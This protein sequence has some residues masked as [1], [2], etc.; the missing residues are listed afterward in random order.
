MNI[1][2]YRSGD[3]EGVARLFNDYRIFYG[4]NPD[5][6]LAVR[7]ISDRIEN[8]ESVIFVADAGNGTLVGL[9]Q[10][11]PTFCSVAAVPIYILYDLFV[12][13]NARRAGV[14]KQLL[15]AAIGQ[16]KT[17]GKAR[18]DLT[19]AKQNFGAQALYESL[20]WKRDEIFYTYNLSIR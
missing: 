8:S 18:V 5:I 19:T 13:P 2:K 11:Y 12:A 20:G 17:E 7:F 9:C 14:A 3:L 4:Q 1:R 6:G 15:L 10:L 16:A